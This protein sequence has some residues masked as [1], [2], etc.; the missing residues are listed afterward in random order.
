[1]KSMPKPAVRR[2][3]SLKFD[4]RPVR[5]VYAS[6]ERAHSVTFSIDPGVDVG[7]RVTADLS[8]KLFPAALAEIAL[9]AGHDISR[10]PDGVY[11]VIANSGGAPIA[12]TPIREEDLPTEEVP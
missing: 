1:M 10:R 3:V 11:R 7:A 9:M 4:S 12:E 8:G 6:L 5:E 2:D